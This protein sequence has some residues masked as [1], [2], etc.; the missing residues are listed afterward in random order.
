MNNII[1]FKEYKDE[2]KLK[3]PIKK[4][5]HKT[6]FWGNTYVGIPKFKNRCVQGGG[7]SKKEFLKDCVGILKQLLDEKRPEFFFDCYRVTKKIEKAENVK[8]FD[9]KSMEEYAIR[10]TKKKYKL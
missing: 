4:K 2:L 6:N 3:K 8:R 10:K 7:S 5:K 1:Q 9:Y